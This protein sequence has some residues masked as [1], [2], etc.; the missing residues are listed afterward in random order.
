MA[1]DFETYQQD[2][3]E[4]VG[5]CLSSME[6]Q[7]ILFVGA[8]LA[9]RY[10]NAPTWVE[11]LELLAADCP[12]IDK[13]FAYYRQSHPELIDIGEVFAD[14]YKEWAWSEPGRFPDDLFDGEQHPHIFLKHAV[15]ER[16]KTI[17]PTNASGITDDTLRTEATALQSVHPHA[18]IT[19]NYDTFLEALFPQYESVVG[20]KVLHS[21]YSTIGEVLKIH[22]CVSDPSSLVLTRQDYD[23]FIK[24]RK[25]LSAKL[26]AFF[27]EHPLLFVGY[28][29]DDPNI[30]YILSDIDLL[31]SANNELIPN[32]YI[33]ERMTNVVPSEYPPR[34]KVISIDG[35]CSVRIK[36]I[37]AESF[38]WVFDVFGQH[39]ALDKVNVKL[40][41]SLLHRT[42]NIVRHDIPTKTIQVDYD[43]LEHLLNTEN[44]LATL[45]GI[46]THASA[47]LIN[48]DFPYTL[49][50]VAKQL[51]YG[52]WHYAN[53]IIQRVRKEKGIDIKASDNQYHIGI[54]VGQT[55]V[56]HKYSQLCVDLLSKVKAGDEYDPH[57]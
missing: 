34:E 39:K 18:I 16:L 46:Q 9:K 22:G 43:T 30:K 12:L 17:T 42:Y 33:L 1:N 21:N 14:H 11:L 4:D 26:L 50:G 32:I 7:P 44:Q 54:K 2:V 29:A 57:V 3:I 31:L 6:C 47:S 36:S 28:R 45:L 10:F 53:V 20:E 56:N 8:G 41:R 55:S 38:Q 40:L 23:I 52:Y 49:T 27:A 25:Y 19:T 15:C 5:T 35:A 51:G 37:S 48:A 13:P 24:K